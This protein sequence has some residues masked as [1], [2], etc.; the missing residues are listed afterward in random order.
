MATPTLYEWA[1]GQ[2]ALDRLTEA[3]YTRVR[4]DEVLAPVF[5]HMPDDHPHHVA[6][7][8]AEVFGA[9]RATPRSTAA[10]RTWCA[11]TSGSA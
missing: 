6:L 4:A 3:F 8:F 9:R 1:G 10:I 7:W 5:A 2:E 11:S